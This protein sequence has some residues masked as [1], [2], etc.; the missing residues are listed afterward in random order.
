MNKCRLKK[1]ERERLYII[2]SMRESELDIFRER[3]GGRG[4][5]PSLKY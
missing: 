4:R 2:L 3:E 5:E 1:G